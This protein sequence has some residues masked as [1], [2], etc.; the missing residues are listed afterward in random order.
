MTRFLFTWEL[1]ANYGHLSR[2]VPIAERLREAGHRVAFA[3]RDTRPAAEL[4]DRG[5]F[6]YVQAP[7]AQQAPRLAQAPANYAEL[8]LAEA[9]ADRLSLLGRIRA[10][11][12]QF[13]MMKPDMIVA[14]H[15]P[16]ALLAAHIVGI[17]A[18]AVGSGFEIPPAISPF[19]S[20]RPWEEIA[21]ERLAR[22][23]DLLLEH[24]GAVIKA[25]GGKTIDRMQRLFGSAAVLT[26]FAELD[27]YGMREGA[28]YVGSIHGMPNAVAANWP[29]GTGNRVFVYLRPGQPGTGAVLKALASSAVR[30]VCAIPGGTPELIGK[31]ASA[32]LAI[33][34]RPVAVAPLL[35]SADAAIG[36]GGAGM[37]AETLLAG[38]PSLTIPATVEQYLGAMRVQT[39]GAGLVLDKKVDAASVKDALKSLLSVTAYRAAARSFAQKYRDATSDRSSALAAKNILVVSGA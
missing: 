10:W 20:I 34:P 33:Y 39:L 15:A 3:V 35:A 8:L 1:G 27:H 21:D 14:D 5:R 37:L 17:P 31:Y 23:E 30:A 18:I 22:A 6:A 11:H 29:E 16:T 19:P 12:T 7:L 2:D 4:L 38:V 36:Y 24:V 28:N 9:W 32:R 25:L 26:T 13:A